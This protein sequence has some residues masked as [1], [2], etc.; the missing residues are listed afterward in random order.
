MDGHGSLPNGAHRSYTQG[1]AQNEPAMWMIAKMVRASIDCHTP[2]IIISLSPGVSL[3]TLSMWR[4]PEVVAKSGDVFRNAF[5]DA[6][7]HLYHRPR[8]CFARC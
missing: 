2:L 4:P 3:L 6:L 8:K 5:E 1:Y 7:Q